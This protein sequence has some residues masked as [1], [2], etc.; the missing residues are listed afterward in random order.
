MSTKQLAI[1][2]QGPKRY[3]FSTSFDGVRYF[4]TFQ[5]N[6][7]NDTWYLDIKDI[8]RTPILTGLAGLTNSQFMTSRFVI[9]DF[10]P[11]G[12]ILIGDTSGAGN[13]PSY[14]NF[15]DSVSAFYLSVIS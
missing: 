2:N 5:Y 6:K 10:L 14:E 9:D 11:F 12:E 3:E 13:D 8:D 4:F 7:R 15:G 1:I